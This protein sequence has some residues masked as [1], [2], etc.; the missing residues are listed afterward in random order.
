[1]AQTLL[2]R[3]TAAETRPWP[4]TRRRRDGD[5]TYGGSSSQPVEVLKPRLADHIQQ[6]PGG[7]GNVA[8]QAVGTFIHF[9]WPSQNKTLA[10]SM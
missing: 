1:M 8:N 2:S 10:P 5:P 7:R 3:P 4:A 6:S 9:T